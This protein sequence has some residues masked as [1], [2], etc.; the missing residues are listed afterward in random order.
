MLAASRDQENLVHSHHAPTKQQPKTPGARYQ[1][2]P[3]RFGRNDENI[4]VAFAGKSGIRGTVNHA[5]NDRVVPKE[6]G[7]RLVTP[8]GILP[9]Y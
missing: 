9:P 5:G 3:L 7:A 4:H 8:A 2:T 6:T 1:K